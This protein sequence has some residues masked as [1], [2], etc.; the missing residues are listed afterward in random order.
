MPNWGA[1]RADLLEHHHRAADNPMPE[2]GI[3][4]AVDRS[5]ARRG[6]R[7]QRLAR[8]EGLAGSIL[9]HREVKHN[10]VIRQVRQLAAQFLHRKIGQPRKGDPVPESDHLLAEGIGQLPVPWPAARDYRHLAAVR[11]QAQ[12]HLQ[13]RAMQ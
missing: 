10:G 12:H 8:G 5:T 6:E 3:E 4:A 2:V 11:M 7:I 9:K 1:F 13:S